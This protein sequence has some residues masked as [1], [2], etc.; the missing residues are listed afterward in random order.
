[1]ALIQ[2]FGDS[3]VLITEVDAPHAVV[4]ALKS[5]FPEIES[6]AGIAGVLF[7]SYSLTLEDLEKAIYSYSEIEKSSY[8]LHTVPVIYDGDDLEIAASVAGLTVDDL[9]LR[10]TETTWIVAMLGFAPGFPYL[11]PLNQIDVE[12]FN[13]FKRLDSPRQKV[14]SGSVAIASGMSCIYPSSSPGGWQ[15]IGRTELVMFDASDSNPSLL[16]PGDRVQFMSLEN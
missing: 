3:A 14:P 10:H 2:P 7:E 9:I 11:I 13:N 5:F 15:L 16:Q 1:M 12:F 6:R 8:S 4:A